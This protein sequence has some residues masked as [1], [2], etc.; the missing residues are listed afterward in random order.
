MEL[1][2]PPESFEVVDQGQ[3]H[4]QDRVGGNFYV[5]K[6]KNGNYDKKAFYATYW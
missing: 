4:A 5:L 2:Y 1:I 3:I 6:W